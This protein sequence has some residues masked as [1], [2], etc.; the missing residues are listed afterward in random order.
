MAPRGEE[1]I[2]MSVL[3]MHSAPLSPPKLV[4]EEATRAKVGVRR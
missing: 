1:T 4:G 2:L 3:R